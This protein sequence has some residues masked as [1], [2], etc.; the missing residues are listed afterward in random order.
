MFVFKVQNSFHGQILLPFCVSLFDNSFRRWHLH[1]IETA[2]QYLNIFALLAASDFLFHLSYDSA[3]AFDFTKYLQGLI[4]TWPM[5]GEIEIP[6]LGRTVCI[7]S[8]QAP[9]EYII[10]DYWMVVWIFPLSY[11]SSRLQVGEQGWKGDACQ[12]PLEPNMWWVTAFFAWT[13]HF[14]I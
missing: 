10:Q 8:V 3:A 13:L 1:W 11:C 12:V 5:H 9:I 4:Q 2:H 14:V 7:P 6:V